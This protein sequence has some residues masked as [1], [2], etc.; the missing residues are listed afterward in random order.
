MHLFS[1]LFSSWSSILFQPILFVPFRNQQSVHGG[2]EG[3]PKSSSK[4]RIHRI[5]KLKLDAPGFCL[6]GFCDSGTVKNRTLEGEGSENTKQASCPQTDGCTRRQESA[7]RS[8]P[9]GKTTRRKGKSQ[10]VRQIWR[11]DDVEKPPKA[12]LKKR[13]QLYGPALETVQNAI[14]M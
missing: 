7:Q 6:Y 12:P 1:F 13:S 9:L 2:G 8:D 3:S 11:I 10:F 14:F 4:E 5:L